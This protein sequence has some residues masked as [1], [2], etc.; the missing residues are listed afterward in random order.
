MKI[1]LINNLYEP[2][3]RG[4]AEQVVRTLAQGLKTAQ[5]E[6]F[7][8]TT[9][10]RVGQAEIGGIKVFY[11]KPANLFWFGDINQK[12]AWLRLFWHGLDMFNFS[13]QKQVKEILEKEKPDIV[14]THNLKGISYLIPRLLKKLKIKHLHTI[15]DIQLVNPTGLIIVGQENNWQ[16]NFFLTKLY[17][18]INRWLFGSPDV[19]IS[20]SQWL[21]NFYQKRNFF[22]NSKLVHLPNPIN[23]SNELIEK[24]EVN[25][26]F[27]FIGQLEEHKG[28]VFLVETLKSSDLDFCLIIVGEGREEK[29]I[30]EI[31]SNDKRFELIGRV[32][33]EKI[34]QLFQKTKYLIVPSL[35]Y[36]NSPTVIYESLANTTPVIAADIGGVAELIK[37]GENGF[38][39]KAGDREDLLGKI[40]RILTASQAEYKMMSIIARNS[41]SLNNIND[42]LAHFN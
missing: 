14:N 28:I 1:C 41:I 36:E 25:N 4:G 13:G 6:V 30:K 40:K 5:N 15:H 24:K 2:Y 27:L 31:I 9:A 11:L 12:P 37:D 29:K 8:I 38:I 32:E 42:Y 26:N 17:E 19:I 22:K 20:P 21:L 33:H 18:K 3:A 7:V 10:K 39:F 34:N 23:I 35:C 16:Q